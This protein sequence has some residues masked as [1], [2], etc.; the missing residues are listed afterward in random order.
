VGCAVING[1]AEVCEEQ[2]QV[3]DT[4][5][6]AGGVLGVLAT[7]DSLVSDQVVHANLP[8]AIG[9]GAGTSCLAR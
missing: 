7:E 3:G 2:R 1:L 9:I 5:S 4:H 6:I 8:I